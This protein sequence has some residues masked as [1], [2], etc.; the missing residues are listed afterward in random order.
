MEAVVRLG[1]ARA[2][3]VAAGVVYGTEFRPCS[4]PVCDHSTL[5]GSVSRTNLFH[6]V[7]QPGDYRHWRDVLQHLSLPFP[8]NLRGKAR[9]G[10][11]P[12]RTKL[13]GIL[14]SSVDHDHSG[15]PAFLRNIFSADRTAVHGPGMATQAMETRTIAEAVRSAADTVLADAVSEIH[16]V[17]MSDVK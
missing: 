5:P 8:D 17:T 9:D 4:A 3:L 2:G 13:L 11:L 16:R 1:C 14:R 7:Q 12:H 10:V 15:D 6:S